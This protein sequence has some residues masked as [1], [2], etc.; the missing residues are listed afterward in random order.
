MT[1]KHVL[2]LEQCYPPDES[3]TARIVSVLAKVMAD[4]FRVTILAGR[5][6][7]NVR[8][9]PPYYL[10]RRWRWGNVTLE[11]VGST[12]FHRGRMIA[13]AANYFSYLGFAFL[14]ALFLRPKPDLLLVMTDPPPAPAV[15]ALLAKVLRVPMVY[16]IRDFHPDMLLAAGV[17]QENALIRG[18]DRMHRWAMRQARLIIVLGEDMRRRVLEKGIDP[19]KVVVVRDGAVPFDLETPPSPDHPVIREIRGDR[20][21]V[22][23][24]AGNLGFAGAFDTL[25]E[26]AALLQDDEDIGMVF[27]GEGALKPRL[28]Q[29][30]REMGLS[31]VRFLPYF[32]YEQVPY[33]LSAPDVH[34]VTMKP[35]LS[36]LVVPSKLYPI[37]MAGKPVLAAVPEDSDIALLVRRHNFGRVVHPRDPRQIAEAIREMARQ[38]QALAQMSERARQ[39]APQY[40]LLRLAEVFVGQLES[41]LEQG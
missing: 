18:W 31:N 19:E 5:P 21:F 15:G 7:Y 36:G 9:K 13:R 2:I 24:H 40:D 22:V 39:A 41:V 17:V 14:R 35:G 28:Q 37:L 30:A 29:K 12:S 23:V 8:E 20:R 25:L 1:L 11:R 32:P 16:N 3:P 4:R 34:I 33:V 26:A 10:F 27:V 6:F 38:P